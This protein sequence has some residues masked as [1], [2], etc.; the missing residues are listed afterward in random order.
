MTCYKQQGQ[1]MTEML[2][3]S[4]FVLV[5]LFLIVPIVGKYIDIKQTTISAARY[6][7]WERTVHLPSGGDLPAGFDSAPHRISDNQLQQQVTQRLYNE[8]DSQLTQHSAGRKLWRYHDGRNIVAFNQSSPVSTQLAHQ[9]VDDLI[10]LTTTVIG[11]MGKVISTVTDV[12]GK[13]TGNES[14]DVIQ[15]NGKNAARVAITLTP[16]P[17]FTS[18]SGDNSTLFPDAVVKFSA[19]SQ[20]YSMPWSAGGVE[21]LVENVKPLAPAGVFNT[22]LNFKLPILNF[23][24]KDVA[25]VALLSPEISSVN[26]DVDANMMSTL[27]RD[28]YLSGKV[29]IKNHQAVKEL[30]QYP[31]DKFMASCNKFG[32]CQEKN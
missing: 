25:A 7:A 20:V 32:F 27:P 2:I 8:H 16:I 31:N 12:F 14:F 26:F 21:H 1:A 18:L 19:Q 6:V 30:R 29:K 5:P 11:G 24:L 23:K 13:F 28:R 22:L 9:E 3:A 4:A 15:V 17:S 10:G